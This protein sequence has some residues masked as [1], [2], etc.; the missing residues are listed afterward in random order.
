MLNEVC[1]RTTACRS[2]SAVVGAHNKSDEIDTAQNESRR[3][4]RGG[5]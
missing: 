2:C 5:D 3:V 1:C 4:F